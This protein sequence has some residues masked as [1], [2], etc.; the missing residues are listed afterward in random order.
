MNKESYLW[1]EAEQKQK[2]RLLLKCFKLKIGVFDTM[3]ENNRFFLKIKIE[4]YPKIKKLWFV[5]IKKK[6]VTGFAK[7][8]EWIKKYH[9]FLI[10]VLASLVL[11][12]FLTHV[13][14]HVEVIH[15]KKEIRDLVMQSLQEK[16]IK[17]NTLKKDFQEIEK[18]KKEILEEYPEKLEWLEIEQTGMKVIVRVE[19][20]KIES[21]Q[22]EKSACHII[23]NQD[24][25][26]KDMVFSKG[27]KKVN[28]N[29]S[30][31][32][33]DILISGII[34]KDEE[35]KGIVCASGEVYGE[36]WYVVN[37]SVPLEYE[38]RVRTGKKRWNFRFRNSYYDD[39]LFKSRLDSYEEE[40]QPLFQIFGQ[41][42]SFVTQYEVEK[43]VKTYTEEEAQNIGIEESLKKITSTLSEK[44]KI[45]DKKVLKKEK[46]NSTMNIEIFVSVKKSI[47]EVQ[48]FKKEE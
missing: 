43:K 32:K 46:N 24:A 28:I 7:W 5:K 8:Q 21:S 4:D 36:V 17:K 9:I 14:V 41:E 42:I 22:I 35:I 44:E 38:E 39:F 11:L 23:A 29:D 18:I 2:S 3:E 25:Y 40:K 33:G 30:V 37:T 13:I 47:G 6:N 45:L 1:I 12:F 34:S 27:E 16:G 15:S 26:I 19:E 48:E 31:K 10:G 20:R